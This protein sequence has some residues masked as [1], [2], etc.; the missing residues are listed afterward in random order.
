MT[1]TSTTRSTDSGHNDQAVAACACHL[2]DA[3]LLTAP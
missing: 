2:Y 1:T 3:D